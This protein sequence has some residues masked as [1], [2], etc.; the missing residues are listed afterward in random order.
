MLGPSSSVLAG[1]LARLSASRASRFFAL[2]ER[3]E[4]GIVHVHLAGTF[5]A[6]GLYN[7]AFLL[8]GRL[9]TK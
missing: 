8:L 1:R 4:G 9:E 6:V 3:L 7:L 2:L 5:G